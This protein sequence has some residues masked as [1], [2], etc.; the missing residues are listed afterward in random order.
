MKYIFVQSKIVLLYSVFIIY[1]FIMFIIT[2]SKDRQQ[3]C[4]KYVRSSVD[5]L[6]IVEYYYTIV[7]VGFRRYILF[8]SKI[9]SRVYIIK[10]INITKSQ[11]D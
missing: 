2:R 8:R 7:I 10:V 11:E 3:I 1:Y 5:Y 6:N 4:L 9:T